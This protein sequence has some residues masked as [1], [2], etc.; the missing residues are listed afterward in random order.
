MKTLRLIA[1]I[2]TLNLSLSAQIFSFAGYSFNQANTPNVAIR[3]GNGA[4][5][6]GA[7]FSSGTAGLTTGAITNFPDG[8]GF[9]SA[10]SIGRLVGLASSGVRALRLPGGDNGTVI[11]HG[12]ETYWSS[13]MG[14]PNLSGDDFV[15]YESA[16]E[17]DA[18]EGV[19][20]R[21][22]VSGIWTHWF[23]LCQC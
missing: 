13:G 17:V 11:R 21:A 6:D 4:V 7:V 18:A 8:I 1:I 9:N 14:V 10:L 2:L 12:V 19:M 22:R 3:F 23:Y 5:L 16:S 15:I 20:A